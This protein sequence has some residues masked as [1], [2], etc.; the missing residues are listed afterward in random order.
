MSSSVP[1]RSA[2]ACLIAQGRYTARAHLGASG[3][4]TRPKV[5]GGPGLQRSSSLATALR[6]DGRPSIVRAGRSR[7]ARCVC[8][9]HQT[10][11]HPGGRARAAC[12]PSR[13][14]AHGLP[15]QPARA[16]A[17]FTASQTQQSA[18][19]HDDARD[20][21]MANDIAPC[22]A[23]SEREDDGDICLGLLYPST[24]ISARAQDQRSR[25]V[26]RSPLFRLPAY[27]LTVVESAEARKPRMEPE[28]TPPTTPRGGHARRLTGKLGVKSTDSAQD[29][30]APSTPR[31]SFR[32]LRGSTSPGSGANEPARPIPPAAM[33]AH[34]TATVSG[35]RDSVNRPTFLTSRTTKP[36]SG[37]PDPDWR[38]VFYS[39]SCSS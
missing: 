31:S 38:T 12:R 23:F 18:V 9:S 32:L 29:A 36:C 7:A 19:V 14:S 15:Q 20:G 25:A 22:P 3:R 34:I 6:D 5:Y 2:R 1:E 39:P 28:P 26:R 27:D 30:K 35:E 13:S 33:A 10:P 24:L 8:S 16:S 37:T 17:H 11:A 21:A 4:S